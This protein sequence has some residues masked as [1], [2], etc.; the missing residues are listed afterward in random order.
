MSEVGKK[1]FQIAIDGPVGVGSST[2]AKLVAEKLNFLFVDTGAM[3]RAVTLLSLE[4]KTDFKE[5]EVV[6]LVKNSSIKLRRPENDEKDGRLIT[7]ILN[8]KDVSWK[9]RSKEVSKNVPMVAAMP[10]VREVLVEF[11]QEIA[12]NQSVVM[13]GRDITFKVLPSADLKIYLTADVDERAKR[14][15]KQILDKGHVVE[16]DIIKNEIEERDETDMNREVDPL[17]IVEDVWVLDSTYMNIEEVV[18]KII[19][20]FETIRREGVK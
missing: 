20:K 15:H 9:I 6:K 18:D 14:R 10:K 2:T 12:R 19:D 7:V 13:E 17:Q 5:E 8:E 4:A 3:Y 16:I 1:Y 11:Q